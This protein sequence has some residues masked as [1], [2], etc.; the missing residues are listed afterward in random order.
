VTPRSE[1]PPDTRRRWALAFLLIAVFMDVLDGTIVFVAL[2]RIAADLDATY[3]ALEWVVAGYTLA[4]ALGLITFGRLGDIVGRKAVFMAGVVGF[5]IASVLAGLAPTGEFLIGARVLQG[6]M[7]SAMVPQVL[8]IIQVIFPGPRRAAAFAAYG[9]TLGLAAI[10]G[11]MLGGVLTELDLL[12]LDWRPIFLINLPV[13]LVAVVGAA[14]LL[15]ESRA[16]R[17]PRL[18][19]VG[20][21]LATVAVLLL[22]YPLVEGR[23][24]GWPV[25]LWPAMALAVPVTALFA[26]WERRVARAHGSPLVEPALFRERGFVAGLLVSFSFLSSLGSFWFVLVLWLQVGLDYSPLQTALVGVGSPVASMVVAGAAVALAP[27][28]GRNQLALGFALGVAAIL[29]FIGPVTVAGS[30]VTGLHAVPALFL[31]GI[32]LGLV[33]PVLFDFILAAVPE[34]EAGSASGVVH[35]VQQIGGAL[36]IAVVGALFFGLL[37][38]N[39]PASGAAQRDGLRSSLT[40]AGVPAADADATT[41]AFER[42]FVDRAAA[43]DPATEPASCRELDTTLARLPQPGAEA[44]GT[45]AATSIRDLF[46]TSMTEVLWYQVA[47]YLLALGLTFLLPRHVRPEEWDAPDRPAEARTE[48]YAKSATGSDDVAATAEV[49]QPEVS[50]PSTPVD[51]SGWD[52]RSGVAT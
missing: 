41:A 5:T 13:G 19:L 11:P 49:H 20:V 10:A 27:R 12:G 28:L 23:A 46:T 42:C 31:L 52:R 38:A 51:V 32:A 33:N 22:V 21:V 37:A 15:P 34:R 18:D 9:I 43:D 44:V 24:L 29:L 30:S 3:A 39:G 40:A 4:F 26:L 7:A 6:L 35:T 2:P 36:G 16:I 17:S 25:W 8:A 45:A 47:A 14:R 48:A 50:P 1:A